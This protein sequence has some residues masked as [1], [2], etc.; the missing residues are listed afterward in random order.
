MSERDEEMK[1]IPLI[2]KNIRVDGVLRWMNK[3]SQIL[4]NT[5]STSKLPFPFR[6]TSYVLKRDFSTVGRCRRLEGKREMGWRFLHVSFMS[7][8]Y[9]LFNSLQV[10]G[11]P[12]AN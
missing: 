1:E 2:P 7:R 10:R 5:E 6:C 9:S 3:A 12:P 8:C 11:F 4:P